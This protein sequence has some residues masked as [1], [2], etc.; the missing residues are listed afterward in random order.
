VSA[1]S[2]HVFGVRNLAASWPPLALSCAALILAAGPRLRYAAAA[3][4]LGAFALGAGKM[5]S[6]RWARSDFRA[7]ADFI[8]SHAR[9]HDVVIDASGFLSPG[10][11]TGL[12]VALHTHIPVL[13]AA[14][15]A[16]VDHPFGIYDSVAP[17][18]S[19]I[20]RALAVA[21]GGRIIVV[22]YPPAPGHNSTVGPIPS[23]YRLIETRNLADVVPLSIYVWGKRD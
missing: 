9:A 15:P 7:A 2:T 21:H 10:P 6:V 1:V 4:A 5:L 12:D 8:A 16:E 22:T 11:L 13:R 23:G 18:Q 20:A 3:L 17:V 19:V 14:A